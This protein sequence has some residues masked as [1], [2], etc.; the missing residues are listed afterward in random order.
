MLPQDVKEIYC[1]ANRHRIVRSIR[2]QTENVPADALLRRSAVG[3]ADPVARAPMI[4]PDVMRELRYLE[5]YTAKKIRNLRIGPYTSPLR[6][7][8]FDFDEHRPYR[9]RGRRAADRLE[10]HRHD[11]TRPTCA[12]PTP[13]AS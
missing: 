11:S 3:G 7:T 9:E 4:P 2:A 1:D 10:R 5:V 13:S 12:R 8:G 6:G